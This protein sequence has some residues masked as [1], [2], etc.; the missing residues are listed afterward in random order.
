MSAKKPGWDGSTKILEASTGTEAGSTLAWVEQS[1]LNRKEF[2]DQLENSL[3]LV[4]LSRRTPKSRS[5]SMTQKRKGLHERHATAPLSPIETGVLD[6]LQSLLATA[7]AHPPDSER[8]ANLD[9][10]TTAT[11]STPPP[12]PT[13]TGFDPAKTPHAGRVVMPAAKP[14]AKIL[15]G[16]VVGD[17][18]ATLEET[19]S[20]LSDRD[21]QLRKARLR[22]AEL[23]TA[24]ESERQCV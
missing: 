5:K 6:E 17:L 1:R 22:E 19:R 9:D 21:E 8:V 16:S 13:A 2:N 18:R 4:G 23:M 20:L 11:A 7:A 3:K 14:G 10:A 12:P 15:R 24:L